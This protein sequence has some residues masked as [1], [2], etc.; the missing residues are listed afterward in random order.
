[1]EIF[2]QKIQ[3]VIRRS[4]INYQALRKNGVL[5]GNILH[6]VRLKKLLLCFCLA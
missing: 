6:V 3:Q 1:M 2:R 4:D 5:D